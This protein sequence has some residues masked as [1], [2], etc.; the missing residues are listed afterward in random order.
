MFVLCLFLHYLNLMV[1]TIGEA[2]NLGWR[3]KAR[4]ASG[5]REGLKFHSRV[6]L[7]L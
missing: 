6:H 4:C 5:K 1:E 3:L 7:D 2:F